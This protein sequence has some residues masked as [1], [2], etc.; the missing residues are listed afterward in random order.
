MTP[1]STDY[2]ANALLAALKQLLRERRI[3]YQSIADSLEVS[4]P[5]VKRMLN[6]AN[7]PIDRLFAICRIAQIDPVD[8]FSIAAKEYPKHTKFTEDQDTLFFV[9]P[10]FLT[11]F[12]KLADEGLTPDEIAEAEG[13]E[14]QSTQK[15]LA[16]LERVGLIERQ[17][18]SKV[19]LLVTPPFGFGP[20]SKVL[21]SQHAEFLQHTVAQVLA[22]ER[23]E[24]AF[25]ILKPLRLQDG[26]YSEMVNELIAVVDKYAYHSEHPGNRDMPNRKQWSLAIAAG[27]GPSEE[28]APLKAL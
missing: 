25:A 24:G 11:Y 17:T 1:K 20:D 7:L 19:R 2:E 8:V 27:P 23:V 14:P 5:T 10:E 21:R 3:G 4:L 26:M 9:R 28:P 18:G 22:P 6:K 16:G 13:L 15:Y 12:M